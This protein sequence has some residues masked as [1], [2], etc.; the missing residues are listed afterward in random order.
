MTID[1]QTEKTR[2]EY[3]KVLECFVEDRDKLLDAIPGCPAHGQGCVP[4]AVKWVKERV[5][6]CQTATEHATPNKPPID[7]FFVA[8]PAVFVYRIRRANGCTYA[9]CAPAYCSP[10]DTFDLQAGIRVAT[11]RLDMMRTGEV[12]GLIFD[13]EDGNV[14]RREVAIE[15]RDHYGTAVFAH[16]PGYLVRK[17]QRTG[18]YAGK[19][20]PQAGIFTGPLPGEHKIEV[21]FVDYPVDSPDRPGCTPP[22]GPQ[23][24][25]NAVRH[26][27]RS[28]DAQD[29]DAAKRPG[30]MDEQAH[31][32]WTAPIGSFVA[33]PYPPDPD[34][35]PVVDVTKRLGEWEL[36]YYDRATGLLIVAEKVADIT[37]SC[38]RP[39]ALVFIRDSRRKLV[40][41]RVPYPGEPLNGLGSGCLLPTE[42]RPPDSY[43]ANTAAWLGI[44][45]DDLWRLIE[46]YRP[47]ETP[48]TGATA[49]QAGT[50]SGP[51][52]R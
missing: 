4:H 7:G 40:E 19:A 50:V 24:Y 20:T 5:V 29:L 22:R 48:A 37:G 8:S 39:G 41:V 30:K 44:S 18:L 15:S 28:P 13:G 35:P 9:T 1:K 46:I 23:W 42:H 45:C 3:I 43:M 26:L 25:D 6:G 17:W 21:G 32:L 12:G 34:P 16:T 31:N 27:V 33:V 38:Q 51:S 10:R 14:T 52:P 11:E 36:N 49:T 2:D 47:P